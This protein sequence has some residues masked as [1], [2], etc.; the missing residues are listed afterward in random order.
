MRSQLYELYGGVVCCS[1]KHKLFTI[2][3]DL[4]GGNHD[5]FAGLFGG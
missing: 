2:K 4:N 1:I 5:I 3:D